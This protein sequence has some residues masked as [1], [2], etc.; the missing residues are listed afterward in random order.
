MAVKWW[1]VMVALACCS[2][3][4]TVMCSAVRLDLRPV[5]S[6]DPGVVDLVE[7]PNPALDPR[8]SDL[9]VT[10]LLA[11]LAAKFDPNYM[12]VTAPE[13][14]VPVVDIPFRRN[15]RGRLVPTGKMPAEIRD[16]D[17]KFFLLP[18][19]RRLRTRISGQLRKKIQQYLWGRTACP[20]HRQWKD[21]GQ[22]FWPRWLLEG[23]CPKG[24]TS[25]SVPAGMYCRA[26]GNQY[27]T[28]LRWHCR[29]GPSG[30]SAVLQQYNSLPGAKATGSMVNPIKVCQWIKVEY[31][32]VTEC[33]CGCATD[34]S[35]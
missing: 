28:L 5:P 19:G 30:P 4:R 21:L 33:G 27:K 13:H 23:H 20:M 12:S 34:V 7:M 9:N 17:T 29:G 35:E 8:P 14:L 24:E 6:N 31:P 1:S 2:I 11:K 26:T 10:A 22:R 16:L 15:R 18:D 32:V 3:C 25:C